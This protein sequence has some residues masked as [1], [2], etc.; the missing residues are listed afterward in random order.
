MIAISL[1]FAK[2][3]I[4]PLRFRSEYPF[5]KTGKCLRSRDVVANSSTFICCTVGCITLRA[6]FIW[7]SFPSHT[8]SPRVMHINPVEQTLVRRLGS[9]HH[10]MAVVI[11]LQL[12]LEIDPIPGEMSRP[13][14]F[15][16]RHMD[17]PPSPK[18]CLPPSEWT[19]KVYLIPV[20][21]MSISFWALNM[22]I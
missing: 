4:H 22:I 6:Q 10:N 2:M 13:I 15:W 8:R 9:S 7:P 14:N 17:H 5:R 1:T 12:F 19:V 18:E 21:A 11:P 20:H 16:G 3:A